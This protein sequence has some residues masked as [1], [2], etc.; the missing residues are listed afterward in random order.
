MKFFKA[1]FMQIGVDNVE[2]DAC[3]KGVFDGLL[4]HSC[5]TEGGSSGSP[6]WVEVDYEPGVE[7]RAVH[8]QGRQ[9]CNIAQY[10]SNEAGEW[11]VEQINNNQ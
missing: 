7:I 2:F 5:D 6:M 4:T 9:I 3:A 1:Y 8:T 11:I 10:I